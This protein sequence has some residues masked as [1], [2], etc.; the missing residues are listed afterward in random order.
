MKMLRKIFGLP[1]LRVKNSIQQVCRAD[2]L[3][4]AGRIFELDETSVQ[5]LTK[6]LYRGRIDSGVF[7]NAQ[8]AKNSTVSRAF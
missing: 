2:E 1:L 5:V 8:P 3:P 4:A 7:A 6:Y